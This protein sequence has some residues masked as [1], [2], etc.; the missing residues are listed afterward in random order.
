[1]RSLARLCLLLLLMP[2][3]V[4][5]G[6]PAEMLSHY[7]NLGKA[8]YENRATQ[9]DAVETFKKALDLAPDSARERVNYGLSLIRAGKK[10]EGV[11]ELVQA[12]KQDPTI[13]HTWF[14]LGIAYMRDSNDS[15]A[16]EQLEGMLRLVADEPISHY[17]LGKLYWRNQQPEQ[18][19]KHFERA[20]ELA[21]NLAGPHYQLGIAYR[22]ANRPEEAKKARE[23]FDRLKSQ[24]AGAAVPEDLEWS[25]YAEI[26]ET[27]DPKQAQTVSAAAVLRFDPKVL[28]RGLDA[29][30]SGLLAFDV[31]GDLMP[32]LL[33]WSASGMQVYRQGDAAVPSGLEDL[34]G[35]VSTAPGD[36]DNDGLADVCVLTA[37]GATLY[38]NVGGRFDKHPV[39]LPIG[40]YRKAVWLDFDHDYD[41]DLFLLGETSALVRNNGQ[42]GFSDVTSAFPFAQGRATDAVRVDVIADTQ[43]MDLAVAYAE[44][45]GVLYRD[46]LGG[47]YEAVPLEALPPGAGA[48]VASDVNN[49]GWIDMVV[50]DGVGLGVLINDGKG[51]F[52]RSQ[53][54]QDARAPVALA[55]FE[56]RAVSELAAGGGVFRNKGLGLFDAASP[57]VGIEETKALAVADF[58]GDGKIDIATISADGTLQVLRN[59]TESPNGWLRVGLKGV[60]NL[61]LAPGAKVEVKAGHQYQKKVYAGVPLLF[62]VGTHTTLDTVR[63]TWPNGT[64]QNEIRQAANQTPVYE[65][66]QRLSGSCPMVFTWN[67]QAFEFITDVLGVAPLGASAGNGEYFPTDHDEYVQIDGSSLVATDGRYEIRMTEELR[68]VAYLDAIRLIAVDRPADLSIFTNDKF[69]GPPFPEFRLFGVQEPVYPVKAHDDHGRD[70][71]DRLQRRDGTYPDGFARDYAGVAALHSLTL[72]FGHAAPDNRAILVLNGWVDWADGSTFLGMSQQHAAGLILPALQVK[73]GQGEWETV[74]EDMGIP[75]GKPKTIVVDLTGKFLSSSREVRIV[76]NLCLYWDEIFLG[77]DPASPPVRLT[78]MPAE[79][80]NLHFRGFSEVIVHPERKQPERFV[81]EQARLLHRWNWNPTPGLYTR[82]GD[83]QP[84][85]GAVDDLLVIMG[86][87]DELQLRFDATR[88]PELPEGWK[89]DFLLFVDGWA[90]DGDANTAFS[91]TVEPLPFHGMSQ[92]PY[93]APQAYPTDGVHSDYRQVYNT[94][95]ALRLIR[96]LF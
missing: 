82:Y 79:S 47:T 2:T 67:G 63:I 17:N 30:S 84:L 13:P 23:T 93:A 88:L 41:L 4:W 80:A 28:N 70:V 9:Y 29:A 20:V 64:V 27:I 18:A 21:P 40:N 8:F 11:A 43:G 69:K 7:R 22:K 60:K 76:T 95:P 36:F 56:N 85:L 61:R 31:D 68:E 75:A 87:G 55:D 38:K 26:Y 73:N 32:D 74:I 58:D 24:Q 78:E 12:Q 45:P 71:L 91:Q 77:T 50:G 66:A 46:R 65:E 83:V 62:G 59:M 49:D 90:K 3:A 1:M 44:R 14:N 37:D 25:Y 34:R 92:Y 35:V 16:I 33:L 39:T 42:S 54:P 57:P 10:S 89:R 48:M 5:A 15:Q 6:S 81:Y 96:P 51:G 86:S 19:L 72:D 52:Q 94:R 53:A